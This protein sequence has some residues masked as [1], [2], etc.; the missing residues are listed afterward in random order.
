MFTKSNEVG[1]IPPTSEKSADVLTS[2]DNAHKIDISAFDNVYKGM[3]R[4]GAKL[5]EIIPH[6]HF[7]ADIMFEECINDLLSRPSYFSSYYQFPLRPSISS[8]LITSSMSH[9]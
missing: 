2:L 1:N 3:S 4:V 5:D 6:E 9:M 7:M 8:S